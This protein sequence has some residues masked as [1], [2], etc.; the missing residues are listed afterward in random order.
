MIWV[1]PRFPAL[2]IFCLLVAMPAGLFAQGQARS[3]IDSVRRGMWFS[4]GLGTGVGEGGVG[5][6]AGNFAV[7]WALSPRV[8]LAV[9]SSD[10]HDRLDEFA[11]VTIGTLDVRVQYYPESNAGFYLT[12]GAG[13]GFFLLDDGK[14]IGGNAGRGTVVGLGYDARVG[15]ST[16]ITTFLNRFDVRTGDP[17]GGGFQLGV[18]LTLH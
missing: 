13:L 18:G 9:G 5:G 15:E 16:S 4:G 3:P 12:G 7:G 11:N 6:L 10:L 14:R 17:R 8:L 1:Q 2:S